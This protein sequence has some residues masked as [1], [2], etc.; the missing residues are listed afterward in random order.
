MKKAVI[1]Q[2]SS[3]AISMI[4]K[5]TNEV[6]DSDK[7]LD[8]T[9]GCKVVYRGFDENDNVNYLS[10]FGGMLRKI[11]IIEGRLMVTNVLDFNDQDLEDRTIMII[12]DHDCE[13][14]ELMFSND[15][16]ISFSYK[17]MMDEVL[18][19]LAAI[20]EFEEQRIALFN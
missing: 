5:T 17:I 12:G 1:R 4:G 9:R 7:L 20:K 18:F 6:L 8:L 11:E 19:L 3:L 16:L 15:E 13:A 10:S 2:L 14:F